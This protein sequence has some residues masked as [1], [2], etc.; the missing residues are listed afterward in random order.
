MPVVFSGNEATTTTSGLT[1]G[2]A[3]DRAT[4]GAT[5]RIFRCSTLT[6]LSISEVA[7]ARRTI[8]FSGDPEETSV[9]WKPRA[10]ASMATNTATV[11]AMPS[12]ATTVEGQRSR[13]LFTL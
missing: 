9:A 11:P 1:R 2:P 5:S 6:L 13:T 12:T 10:M 7:P 8:A 3:G 4:P